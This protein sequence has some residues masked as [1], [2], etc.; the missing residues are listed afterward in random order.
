[1][2]ADSLVYLI[3]QIIIGSIFGSSGVINESCLVTNSTEQQNF[4]IKLVWY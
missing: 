3:Y 4:K 2:S 1:M